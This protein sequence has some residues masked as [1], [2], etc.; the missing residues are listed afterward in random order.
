MIT[1]T[2]LFLLLVPALCAA[3]AKPRPQAASGSG[4]QAFSL[5][6]ITCTG[7]KR[8]AEADIIKF[9]GLKLGSTVTA[10]DLKAAASR[11]G[12]SGVFAQVGYRFDGQSADF[13]LQD[14]DRF[15]PATFENFVW[16]ADAELVQRVRSAVPLFNGS[17]PLNGDLSD[18]ISAALDALLK[19]KGVQGHTLGTM[20]GKLGGPIQ[21]MQFQIDGVTARIAEIRFLGAGPERVPLLL[22]ATRKPA[23]ENYLQS[24][25]ANVIQFNA[26]QVYGKLGFLKAQFGAPK[27]VILKDDPAQPALAV[28]VPVQEGDQYSYQTANWSGATAIPLADLARTIH[29]KT[30]APADTVQ[31]GMDLAK[32]KELYATRGYMNAQI[33]STATLED[34]RHT[35][36]FNLQISEGP[37]YHMGKLEVLGPD[38][39]RAE[40][41]KRVWEMRE[42][43]VYDASYVKTFMTRHPRELAALNGWAPRYT[44]TI[45]DDTHV[46]DLSLKFEK[47]QPQAR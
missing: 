41:A 4:G 17:V 27:P 1:R 5:K 11:L 34:S 19:E 30:G 18:Q 31:L 8:F 3:Q 14:A 47:F 33:K 24:F 35:A 22:E 32:V 29:L 23:G 13:T 16:F 38:P 10:G 40:L 7:S 43:D 28:E 2:T 46:V 20:S 21:A 36:V 42:G 9:T 37:L 45:H 6:K 12:Q 44:Q 25:F 26:P 15:V 39:Q